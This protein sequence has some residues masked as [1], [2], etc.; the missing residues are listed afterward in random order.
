MPDVYAQVE[1]IKRITDL[2]EHRKSEING[3][4]FSFE[5]IEREF[6]DTIKKREKF[7]IKFQLL[8]LNSMKFIM[9]FAPALLIFFL[10]FGIEIVQN[11]FLLYIFAT[12]AQDGLG[13]EIYATFENLV[14]FLYSMGLFSIMYFSIFLNAKEKQFAYYAHLA[15]TLLGFFTFMTFVVF[16]VHIILHI[17]YED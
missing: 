10:Q 4:V 16:L 13:Y 6:E 9:F 5:K 14:V 1:P 17:V 15:S 7:F 11:E 3:G 8:Y 12:D 2:M